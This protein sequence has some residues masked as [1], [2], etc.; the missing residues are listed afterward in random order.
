MSQMWAERQ[1]RTNAL[2]RRVASHVLKSDADSSQLFGLCKL[3]WI[4]NAYE[5]E[6]PAYI[7]STKIPALSD[8]AGIDL[9][10]H[11]LPGAASLV[12]AEFGDPGLESLILAHT[13]FTN[14]YKAYRN[15]ARLWVDANRSVLTEIFRQAYLL[16]TDEQGE[17]LARRIAALPPIPKANHPNQGMRPDFLVT[18]VCFALDPRLRF[19]IINGAERVQVILRRIGV[20]DSAATEKYR[21]L[22]S[23]IGRGGVKDAADLDQLGL[24]DQ[25]DLVCDENEHLRYLL[26]EQPEEGDELPS[27]EE[28][29]VERLQQALS[30]IQRRVHN[31]MTNQLRH[32][33]SRWTL[34]EGRAANC[35]Y[36]VLVRDYDRTGNDL[37]IEVKSSTDPSQIRMAIGQVYAYWHRLNGSTDEVH[38]AILLP[39][40]PVDSVLD[41]LDWLEI[42]VLWIE[43]D[44]LHTTTDW[45]CGFAIN[46]PRL[47]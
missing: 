6:N 14:F 45:L 15:S 5:G 2:V 34:L 33:L 21:A 7:Q 41:L 26:E 22:V 32:L 24:A 10:Q 43:K 16:S 31:R 13:G 44:Q 17:R 3:T 8:V 35:K 20:V 42:G 23:L 36:D 1:R 46:S 19:P 30:G 38:C 37:L 9:R 29:E 11:T 12:A 25:L 47:L 28:E 4:T 18:P 39:S 40:Q 27:K